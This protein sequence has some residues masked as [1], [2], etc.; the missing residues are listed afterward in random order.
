MN[1]LETNYTYYYHQQII[2]AGRHMLHIST[3]GLPN[4]A[5]AYKK[6]EVRII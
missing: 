2:I 1:V 4:P 6:Y 5:S 3:V